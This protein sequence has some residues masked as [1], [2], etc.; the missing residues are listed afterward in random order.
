MS[1]PDYQHLMAPL[2]KLASDGREHTFRQAIEDLALDLKL[3]ETD[4]KEMLPSGRQATFDKRIGWAS[5]YLKQAQLL[6]S[7]G[8][9][10]FRITERG[11]NVLAKHSDELNTK[12][13]A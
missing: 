5:T 6:E 1:L 4:R 8:R 13:F 12:F 10:K 7:T 9:G 11:I 3:T 2:L